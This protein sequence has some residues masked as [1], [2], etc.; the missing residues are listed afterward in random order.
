M[1]NNYKTPLTYI[2]L[3]MLGILS[4]AIMALAIL[5][6]GSLI[7]SLLLIGTWYMFLLFI[8]RLCFPDK[9]KK[10][11]LFQSMRLSLTVLTAL[12]LCG[13]LLLRYGIGIYQSYGEQNGSWI[14]VSPYLVKESS[15]SKLWTK[16]EHVYQAN[17]SKKYQFE[18]YDYTLRTNSMGLRN[19][20]VASPKPSGTYRIIALGD[21]FTEGR[22]VSENESWPATLN[23]KLSAHKTGQTFEVVN[24]GISGSDP[25]FE[26]HLLENRLLELEPDMVILTL[27]SS[28][29]DDIIVRGGKGRYDEHGDLKYRQGPWWVGF[30]ANSFIF[31]HIV[32][33]VMELN[34]LFNKKEEE[35]KL[36][37]D[38]K[39]QI[40][41][42]INQFTEL[43]N[44]NGF[45][46]V[47]VFHPLAPEFEEG[48]MQLERLYE[49]VKRNP[50]LIAINVLEN[51]NKD[52]HKA[53]LRQ[54]YYW[55]IDQHYKAEGYAMLAQKI[56]S[57]IHDKINPNSK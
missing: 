12:W 24:A 53:E 11:E 43:G 16:N 55:P 50:A 49:Q 42:A 52:I 39:Q 27:N 21:S 14:Y 45:S 28:D 19:A 25:F 23:A 48:N 47:V 4:L 8:L 51:P 37:T 31:R 18:E 3:V 30:Y 1:G 54:Q 2:G 36:R 56:F 57:G 34:W 13:E 35:Q 40:N 26:L 15:W 10:T 7:G 22:G 41:Q 5:G 32:H 38:A 20:E 44:E 46:C 33:D 9:E 17:F 29:I 6:V